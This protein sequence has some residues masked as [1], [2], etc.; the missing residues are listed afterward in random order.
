MLLDWRD[1][2]EVLDYITIWRVS[3][4]L[5]YHGWLIQ[6]WHYMRPTNEDN[7]PNEDGWL[8]MWVCIYTCIYI[9]IHICIIYIKH[10]FIGIPEEFAKGSWAYE[11]GE[12]K[13]RIIY[14]VAGSATKRF[15][16][17]VIQTSHCSFLTIS[18]L[19]TGHPNFSKQNPQSENVVQKPTV[20][21][22]ESPFL[23]Q[24]FSWDPWAASWTPWTATCRVHGPTRESSLETLS[25]KLS[26]FGWRTDATKSF[27]L[28]VITLPISHENCGGN[29]R[30]KTR[31]K[32]PP[33]RFPTFKECQG[34]LALWKRIQRGRNTKN[35]HT[36]AQKS[37]SETRSE[38]VALANSVWEN[39]PVVQRLHEWT[40]ALPDL[41][42][43]PF[44][45][46]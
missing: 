7:I 32:L 23:G 41:C 4:Q 20:S 8:G 36:K 27:Q 9:Y 3:P 19:V 42:V 14:T 22:Q 12:N 34:E 46:W 24:L 25:E 37:A 10:D 16:R 17:R 5:I 45:M 26:S 18:T 6:G 35:W 38:I 13:R 15:D 11:T 29:R 43:L 30:Q 31:R 2:I 21:P 1:I 40:P 44:K 33:N 39:W 28:P